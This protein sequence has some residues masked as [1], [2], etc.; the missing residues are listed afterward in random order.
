MKTSEAIREAVDKYLAANAQE[1][2]TNAGKTAG[3]CYTLSEIPLAYALLQDIRRDAA[4]SEFVPEWL[5]DGDITE[6]SQA[7][8]FMLAEFM[9]L[10]FEDFG[11]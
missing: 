5:I 7:I 2:Y 6:E 11:D 8:R 3:L 4:G 9:A 1:Y 10:Y